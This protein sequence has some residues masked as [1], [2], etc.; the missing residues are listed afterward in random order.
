MNVFSG[1][2]I[3]VSDYKGTFNVLGTTGFSV[4]QGSKVQ[5]F[6]SSKV[7]KFKGSKGQSVKG[8][9]VQRFKSS[10]VQRFKS[11]NAMRSIC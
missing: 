4:N 11:S 6:K 1:Y 3:L 5:K 8:S 9:K 7:Q 2:H 10:K